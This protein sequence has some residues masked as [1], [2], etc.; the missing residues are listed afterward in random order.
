MEVNAA[1]SLSKLSLMCLFS[2]PI[3]RLREPL[4]TY[5]TPRLPVGSRPGGTF[6]PLTEEIHRDTSGVHIVTIAFLP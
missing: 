3:I 4:S 1:I 6:R 5:S 2:Q